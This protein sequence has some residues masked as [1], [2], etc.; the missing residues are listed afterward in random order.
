MTEKIPTR[1]KRGREMKQVKEGE[2]GE[3]EVERGERT[4][5]W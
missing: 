5:Q 4:D 2:G 3:R 1:K